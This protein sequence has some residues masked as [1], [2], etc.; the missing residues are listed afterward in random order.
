VARRLL[1]AAVATITL[2]MAGLTSTAQAAPAPAPEG[3]AAS[4]RITTKHVCASPRAHR[5]SCDAVKRTDAAAAANTRR[6]ASAMAAAGGVKPAA[7]ATPSGYG[8]A[9]IQS[10]YK[11]A[12]ASSGGRTVAIVDAY[13]DPTAASDL[14]V[15]RSTYGLPAC[16][17]GCFTKINQ[18]GGTSYPAT[19]AGWAEEISLDLDMVSATCPDCK[20]LLVE[21]NS[22]SLTDLGAAVNTAARRAGVKAISNSYGGGDLP[23]SSYG[24][25]YYNHPGI[26]VTASSGDN[27]YGASFPADSQYVTAV[28]GTSL[29]KAS[30]ARGWTETAWSGAG[31]GCSRYNTA[32]PAASSSNTGC[33]RRAEADVSAVADP[34]TGVA[35]Y[36]TTVPSGDTAGWLVFG[37]TS[38]SSPIIA[39]VY[40]LSGNTAGYANAIPYG[41]KAALFD[42]TSGS[43]GNCSTRQLCTARTGWDGPTGLGTPNG[44]GAF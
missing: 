14:A 32:L 11:L 10:A 35:V 9:D 3:A 12:G 18:T 44:T 2:T 19:D 34:A 40:A 33:S 13:D 31:S 20:I 16:G 27:G 15:Y 7:A 24:R 41:N 22:S 4:P 21:A 17:A 36:D 30:N 43:N 26:A 37:G 25:P 29:K 5:A 42:V 38:A 39:S 8:P 1:L 28:G 6:M 23:D